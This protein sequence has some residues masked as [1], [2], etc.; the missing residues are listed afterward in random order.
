MSIEEMAASDVE[1][2]SV[3]RDLEKVA[4]LID[5]YKKTVQEHADAEELVK[6]K[7]KAIKQLEEVD[8]L[9]ALDEAGLPLIKLKTGETAKV[10]DRLYMSIP[11]KNMDEACNWLE[12]H[13]LGALVKAAVVVMMERGETEKFETVKQAL[14]RAAVPFSRVP[15]VNT[16]SVKSA[17]DELKEKGEP[18]DETT[19]ALFGGYQR[20]FVSVK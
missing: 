19:L 2:L 13:E 4:E 12:S 11:K 6:E 20:R 18:V 15:T 1:R 14:L 7:A 16:G 3:P 5:R 17:F 9:N 10:E 8:L